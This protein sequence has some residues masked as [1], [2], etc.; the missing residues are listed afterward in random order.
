MTVVSVETVTD[1]VLQHV[2]RVRHFSTPSEDHIREHTPQLWPGRGFGLART[3]EQTLGI[4]VVFAFFP[5]RSLK[6]RPSTLTLR[7]SDMRS[8]RNTSRA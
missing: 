3:K 6:Q 8:C 7:K 1:G 5:P 4:K 2:R